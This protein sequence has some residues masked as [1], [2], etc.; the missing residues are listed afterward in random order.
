MR[1]RRQGINS[2]AERAYSGAE[3]HFAREI[4]SCLACA[5]QILS[6]TASPEPL[7]K[8]MPGYWREVLR[9][10]ERGSTG[11][12]TC[13]EHTGFCFPGNSGDTAV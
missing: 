1:T 13:Q 10:Q 12:L 8:H 4:L 6:S 2:P 11:A 9:P 5:T 3:A 7:A